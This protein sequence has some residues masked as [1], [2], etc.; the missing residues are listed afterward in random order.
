MTNHFLL[1][2]AN[3]KPHLQHIIDYPADPLYNSFIMTGNLFGGTLALEQMR[4]AFIK[5]YPEREILQYQGNAIQQLIKSSPLELL[6]NFHQLHQNLLV[7]LLADLELSRWT[8]EEQN[9]LALFLKSLTKNH[10][11]VAVSTSIIAN[12][13]Y[14]NSSSI[15]PELWSWFMSGREYTVQSKHLIYTKDLTCALTLEQD[16]KR[17]KFLSRWRKSYHFG[18]LY[19]G[20]LTQDNNLEFNPLMDMRLGL[21]W[22]GNFDPPCYIFPRAICPNCGKVKLIPYSC[23]ASMLSGGHVIKFHCLNC[24]E[25]LAT[26]D[27]LDYYQVLRTYGTRPYYRTKRSNR[28]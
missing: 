12:Q 18:E 17:F 14:S 1:Q 22:F 20:I 7:I 3:L 9:K 2:D 24:H 5:K 19:P 27:A 10:I 15:T 8:K 26:N 23:I 21:C 4:Q 25:R 13:G 28:L 6:L 11:Q 16:E